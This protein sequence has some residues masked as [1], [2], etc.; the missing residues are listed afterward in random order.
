MNKLEYYIDK[1]PDYK[2]FGIEV[3]DK[4]F[5]G[6]C[7][8][9]NGEITIYINILQPEEKQIQTLLHEVGHADFNLFSKSD[10]RW[11]RDTMRVEKEASQLAK[12]YR[13][14]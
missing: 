9:E 14:S 8:K 1:F 10:K 6:Q 2:F 12:H 3:E 7:V 5:F 13:F 11:C 4:R